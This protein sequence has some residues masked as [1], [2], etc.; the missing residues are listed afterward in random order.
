MNSL[1][2]VKNRRLLDW[3]CLGV[4][5]RRDMK[6]LG[7]IKTQQQGVPII[8]KQSE[9]DAGT[10][11]ALVLR[12]TEYRLPRAQR[13]LERVNKGEKLRD[14]DIRFLK[15]VFRDSYTNQS[16]IK[17]NPEYLEIVSRFLSLYAEI[18]TKALENEKT[19]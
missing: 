7:A 8:M 19:G 15:R 5:F 2:P 12:M 6:M 10:I 14:N 11:V 13:L 1:T 9:R 18:T 4:E 17:R 16:L 3:M